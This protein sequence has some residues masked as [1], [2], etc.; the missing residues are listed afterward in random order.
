MQSQKERP[1]VAGTKR[2]QKHSPRNAATVGGSLLLA[3]FFMITFGLFGGTA[4]AAD[5]LQCDGIGDGG[6]QG[7][8]CTVD[9]QNTLDN[10][11]PAAPITSSVVTTT[12]CVGAADAAEAG[13]C[14]SSGPITSTEL[15]TNIDQ[16]NYAVNGGGATLECW[17]SVNN[18]I[19]GDAP[20]TAVPVTVNQCNN[21]LDTGDVR[22]CTPDPS[23][24]DPSTA[25]IIECND[26]VN[27]GGSVLD[28]TVE[29]GSTVSDALVVTVNQCNNSA[30][31]GGSTVICR[32]R[33]TTTIIK[34]T[35]PI[36]EE[37]EETPPGEEEVPPGEEEVPGGEVG[38]PVVVDTTGAVLTDAATDARNAADAA[39]RLAQTGTDSTLLIGGA[40][41]LLLLGAAAIVSARRNSG[42]R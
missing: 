26:S 40:T 11:D 7:I 17:V 34:V 8:V 19:I 20:V 18:T 2:H 39:D 24:T 42:T 10:T 35:P 6:G 14:E 3:V 38:G 31:G 36:E 30:N 22:A 25:T 41:I 27:G 9:V 21:S 16:C 12:R 15:V 4:N 37:E 32:V 1:T 13:L 33:M 5:L 28:C 23:T 29:A